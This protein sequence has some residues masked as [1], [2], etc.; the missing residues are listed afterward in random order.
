[1]VVRCGRKVNPVSLTPP[2][3]YSPQYYAQAQNMPAL[4]E[5]LYRTEDY[6]GLERL[7]SDLPEGT[8]LLVE[9][10]RMLSSV[11]YDIYLYIEI[12]IYR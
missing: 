11:S 7:V 8:P 2:L 12:Y 6:A 10:G 3:R 4:A 9:I 1:V 5:C